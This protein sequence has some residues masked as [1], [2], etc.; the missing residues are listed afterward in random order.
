M[1]RIGRKPIT[2]PESVKIEV[3]DG[4]VHVSGAKGSLKRPILEGI[5]VEID[6]K[7]VYVKRAS[8]DKKI[9][10]YHGLM[11]TLISNMVEGIDKGFEKKLEII[12]I[13]YRAE[14]Q[15]DNLVFYLGYSHPIQFPLP[16]GISA[17]VDKQTLVTIKGID[18][19]LVGQVAAKIRGL[20]KPD[21]YKNKGIKYV[22]EALRK[23]AG[24]SGK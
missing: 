15:G 21:V 9:R 2:L 19:E 12:G 17:Q 22:G 18:K 5:S 20:R 24:K 8:D 6:G 11:R 4:E 16:A 23:K 7:V 10:S 13:G 14:M 1:S 3:R